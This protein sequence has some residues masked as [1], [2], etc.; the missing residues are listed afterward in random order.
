MVVTLEGIT[1]DNV[2]ALIALDM[3][4]TDPE[5]VQAPT[6]TLA[7]AYAGLLQGLDGYC[8]AICTDGKPVG[9]FLIGEAIA[10]DLDPAEARAYGRFYRM[11]GFAIDAAYRGQ[12]I[13]KKALAAMLAEYDALH[14]GVPLVLQ[15]Y[16]EN[17][18]AYMLYQGAGFESTGLRRGKD[19]V[20][21]R[22]Q[23]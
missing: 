1:F 21:M 12:G 4:G 22:V 11:T 2:M 23:R 19:I 14:A 13:G 6:E 20:M 16:E 17:A 18:T 8:R 15:C 10:D 7:F 9:L 5:Y 3:S